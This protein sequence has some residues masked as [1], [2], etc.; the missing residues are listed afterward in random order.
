MTDF[1]EPQNEKSPDLRAGPGLGRQ[2]SKKEADVQGEFSATQPTTPTPDSAAAVSFLQRFHP[3]G[4]WALTGIS[5]D[6]KVIKTRSF[7]PGQEAAYLQWLDEHNGKLNLYFHVNRP[8]SELRKKAEKT[9]IGEAVCLHVDIDPRAGEDIQ[10]E[11]KRALGILRAA[12]PAPSVI[13]FSGGGYQAFWKLE[14]PVRIDGDLALAESFERYNIHLERLYGADNCHNV[15]RIM[16]L[17]GTINLP[18]AKKLKKRRVAALAQLVE[19]N[20]NVYPLSAFTAAPKVQSEETLGFSGRSVVVSGNVQRLESVDDL[21]QWDVPDWLK[22][23][24]VQGNDPDNPTKFPSRSEALFACTCELVRRGVPDDVIFSI[25]TDESF[26]IAESVVEHKRPEKYALRQIDKAHEVV[27]QDLGWNPTNKA[28]E[29]L[30]SLH[31]TITALRLIGLECSYDLFRRRNMVGH[32]QMQELS[33]E[34]SDM[35]E[36][37]IRREIRCRFGFDPGKEYVRDAV[38]ELCALGSF[39]PLLD[40]LHRLPTWDGMPRLDSWL[41]RYLGAKDSPYIRAAGATWLVAAMARAFEPGTKFDHMLVLVGAQGRGKSSALNILAG[42]FFS[43]ANFLDAQDTREVLEA[44]EGAWIVECAELAGMR[45]KDVETLK[46]EITRREDR[47]RPAYARTVVSV[48]RRFVL[49]GTTNSGRFLHDETGNRR[50]WPVEVGEIDLPGLQADRDQIL[51]E[52]LARY[53]SGDFQLFL[54][55][56]ALEGAQQAQEARRT[57]EDGFL[58]MAEG[59]HPEGFYEGTA[60]IRTDTVYQSMGIP[61]ERRRGQLATDVRRA[62]EEAGWKPTPGSVRWQGK[63]QRLYLWAKD[64]PPPP[65]VSAQ[66]F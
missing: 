66:P 25:L 15:D 63:K 48:K 14:E 39:D 61:P 31:N 47:G 45:R 5:P 55:G 64:E 38:L 9:D 65:P 50:F 2:Q 32:H 53:R 44:T 59:L 34:F 21:N 56:E 20:D 6:K 58:E 33:G 57:V 60:A 8:T 35:A 42:E 23:L 49:A 11:Q 1:L 29:P 26:G 24:I 22:V 36:V 16:R 40:H 3:Q 12:Q 46:H 19:F 17:P 30:K 52:A 4:P 10:E 28:G 13:V 7:S 41:V 43:D 27:G 62:M 37:L 51:A 54:T 18:D